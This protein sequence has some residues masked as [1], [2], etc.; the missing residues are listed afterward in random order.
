MILIEH[1]LYAEQGHHVGCK[2][3]CYTA[4]GGPM[5]RDGQPDKWTRHLGTGHCIRCCWRAHR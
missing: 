2:P 4:P 5:R 3:V 1:L